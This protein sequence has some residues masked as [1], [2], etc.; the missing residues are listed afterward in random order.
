MKRKSITEIKHLT[1][2]ALANE[3]AAIKRMAG[4]SNPQIVAMRLKAEGRVEAFQAMLSSLDG[5]DGHLR[6]FA[7]PGIATQ[8]IEQEEFVIA[9]RFNQLFWCGRLHWEAN[10]KLAIR[11]KSQSEAQAVCNRINAKRV[12]PA[13]QVQPLQEEIDETEKVHNVR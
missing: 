13:A 6:L 4:D 9:H 8:I 5:F 2:L 1:S 10:S 11:Y 3:E 12:T 7:K